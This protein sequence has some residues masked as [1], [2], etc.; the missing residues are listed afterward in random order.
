LQE[1]R[2]RIS[3]FQQE[4]YRK[5]N[6]LSQREKELQQIEEKIKETQKRI[7]EETSYLNKYPEN[8]QIFLIN[9]LGIYKDKL[10]LAKRLDSLWQKSL[11]KKGILVY[12]DW[13]F[14]WY[15]KDLD[16]MVSDYLKRTSRNVPLPTEWNYDKE[17]NRSRNSGYYPPESPGYRL[18]KGLA[19]D[20]RSSIEDVEEKMKSIENERKTIQKEMKQLRKTSPKSFI[21][22]VE[23]TITLSAHE[24]KLHGELQDKALKWLYN[25]G[26]IAASEVT[27]PNGKRVDVIGYNENGHIVI[28]EVKASAADFRQDE[29]W[30]TYLEYCDEFY[31]FP[32]ASARSVYYQN[33]EFKGIGLL[34]ETKNNLRVLKDHTT[35]H[36][37][38]EREKIQFVIGKMLSKKYV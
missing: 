32:K 15:V 23:A 12:S 38:K 11:K 30:Q 33:K 13:E 27:F 6:H 34:E 18:P 19:T 31:F 1:K 29:K 28:I 2:Q 36:K 37:A 7:K 17:E 26:Y 25:K 9:H 4:I 24:L 10:V 20:L 21:E 3:D 5:L 22:A 14:I 16:G 8:A 35:V